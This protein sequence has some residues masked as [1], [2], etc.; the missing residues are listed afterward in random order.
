MS[1]GLNLLVSISCITYNH[2]KYIA[3]ALDSFLMQKTNFKY[4]ILIHDDAS[5]DQTPYIIKEYERKYPDIIK[6]IYQKENKYSK[7]IRISATYNWPRAQGKYIASCEGDDYWTDPYKLQKQ[8]DFMEEHPE[9]VYC[10]HAT[11]SI[12][13]NGKPLNNIIKP[14]KIKRYF[15]TD[16][17]IYEKN[18]PICQTSSVMFVRSIIDNLPEYFFDAPQG[19]YAFRIFCSTQGFIGYIDEVMS[20]YRRMSKGSW[21]ESLKKSTDKQKWLFYETI[22]LLHKIND[23]TNKQYNLSVN[24]QIQRLKKAIL[25]TETDITCLKDPQNIVVFSNF[26]TKEKIKQ[27]FRWYTPKAYK[28]LSQTKAKLFQY[29]W[30]LRVSVLNIV[31]HKK[32]DKIK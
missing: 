11:Q 4:E 6:P 2:E 21:N 32:I 3:E 13:E 15:S 9:C 23:Q 27:Y 22:K 25:C 29:M 28:F 30:V 18:G 16:D 7:G 12:S 24:M 26:T 17:I 5:T 8:V 1:G 19:D 20:V 10:C 14:K 31:R